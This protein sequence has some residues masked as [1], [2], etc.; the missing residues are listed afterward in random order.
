MSTYIKSTLLSAIALLSIGST[1][2]I[3]SLEAINKELATVQQDID[4]L[5]NDIR[6]LGTELGALAEQYHALTRECPLGKLNNN[7]PTRWIQWSA[8]K[9]REAAAKGQ[10][11]L[12]KR[13]EQIKKFVI[14]D[15]LASRKA[16][17][18]K[19]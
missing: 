14:Y 4:T 12:N 9:G 7:C 17:L 18:E 8:G 6:K 5:T 15:E 19:K 3:E 11:Q 1:Y 16:L 13:T 10:E 2:G